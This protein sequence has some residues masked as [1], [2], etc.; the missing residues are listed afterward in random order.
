MKTATQTYA[1]GYQPL[2]AAS[3]KWSCCRKARIFLKGNSS[4]SRASVFWSAFDI[5]NYPS[6]I[7]FSS[8][9]F[10]DRR[11]SNLGNWSGSDV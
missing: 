5:I 2:L 6:K 10:P 11:K 3:S 1:R 7:V 4:K 8:R 9:E